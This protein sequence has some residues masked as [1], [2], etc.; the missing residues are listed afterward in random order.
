MRKSSAA[1]FNAAKRRTVSSEYVIPC[2]FEYLGTHHMPFT[3]AS[4]AARR[5]TMSI[6]GPSARIGTGIISMPKYS[7]IEKCLSYPGTGHKNLT[8]SSLHH[9]VEPKTPCVIDLAIVSY[10]M[11][12]LALPWTITCCGS[13]SIN[14]AISLFASSIPSSPP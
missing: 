10:I 7:V 2:G 14:P 1:G 9:G 13:Q 4:S 6:S 8:R 11:L 3:A 12:R 5:S